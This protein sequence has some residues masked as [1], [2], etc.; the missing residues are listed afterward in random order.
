M[1]KQNETG[2]GYVIVMA[3]DT[4]EKRDEYYQNAVDSFNANKKNIDN[5][6]MRARMRKGVVNYYYPYHWK[7]WRQIFR[8]TRDVWSRTD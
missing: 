8:F 2:Y 4:A 1:R 6:M 3:F 7:W 5:L